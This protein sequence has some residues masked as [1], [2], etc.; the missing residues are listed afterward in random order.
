MKY[1]VVKEFDLL[2]KGE[3]LDSVDGGFAFE[4]ETDNSY[5]Y[6]SYSNVIID[7]LVKEGYLVEVKEEQPKTTDNTIDE[8]I[9]EID[10]L[11]ESYKKDNDTV[12]ERFSN[13][14]LP[15]CAKVEADT[16]HSNLTKVLTHI[17]EILTK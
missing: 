14:E 10:R 8:A 5:R 13:G 6:V 2:K 16:V 4:E 11:L 9:A 15:Y 1:K 7:N 17:K 12:S 3:V